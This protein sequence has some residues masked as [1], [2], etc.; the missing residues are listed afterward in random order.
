MRCR[1]L[2]GLIAALI[3]SAWGCVKNDVI[4]DRAGDCGQS[5]SAHCSIETYGVP[6]FPDDH[7]LVNYVEF[8]D[9]G[10][11]YEPSQIDALFD[12]LKVESQYRDLCIVIFVHG[13][14]H[15]DA[16]DDSNVRDFRQLLG[17]I[18]VMEKKLA[19]PRSQRRVVGIYAGWRGISLHATPIDE[20]LTF[21]NR[22]EAAER[23]ADGSVR[24]LLARVKAFR[25]QLDRT[26]WGGKF[27]R[28]LEKPQTRDRLRRTRM[29]TIGHSFGGL[30]VYS[31]LEQYFID[32]SAASL[33]RSEWPTAGLQTS[34]ET[35][36]DK[37]VQGFGDL[38]LVINPAIEAL[39]YE[40]LRRLVE[41]RTQN[42]YA[43][44]QAPVFVEVTSVAAD[45]QLGDWATGLVFPLG[46]FF[47]TVGQGIFGSFR[48]DE[49]DESLTAFGQ[50]N[51]FWTHRLARVNPNP[52]APWS[53]DPAKECSQFQAFNARYR[54]S[55]YL[56]DGW[57]RDYLSG[58]RLT[59]LD[60]GKSDPD[61][62]FWIIRADPS[63]IIDH[64]DIKEPVFEGFVRQLYDDIVLLKERDTARCP[65]LSISE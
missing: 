13:W 28:P 29:L 32:Q 37:E 43:P 30:I 19:D 1:N 11:L 36:E 65:P 53:P 38:V 60:D 46:R 41:K 17:Q 45:G 7:Y 24:E 55:G 9:Q 4:R 20:N 50:Y 61:S 62:P 22:K 42:R 64:D 63:V 44:W 25:D 15:N 14:K 58:A 39:R 21:W 34:P 31:A 33:L 5:P 49:H 35:N 26:T 6:G 8:D 59:Q 27:V 57:V 3:M 12:R 40:P 47:S 56:T 48:G 10:I 2:M 18:A 54:R 51:P 52:P 23:V 16:E